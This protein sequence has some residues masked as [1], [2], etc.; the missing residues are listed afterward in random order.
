MSRAI[1]V[2]TSMLATLVVLVGVCSE[3]RAGSL[4]ECRT[5]DRCPRQLF[6]DVHEF[7]PGGVT[8]ADVAEAHARD[9]VVQERH[10]VEFEKYWVDERE[11]RVYCLSSAPDAESVVSTHRE[12]HGLVPVS[13]HPVTEGQAAAL[14][15]TGRLFLDIHRLGAGNVT[16][17]AVAAAHE[18]DLAVQDDYGVNFVQYWVDE[19]EGVVLCLSEASTSGAVRDTHREAHG[20]MPDRILEVIQGE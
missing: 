10:D 6:V 18:Q 14:R 4:R 12:A 19:T 15:G 9:L 13:V 17:E 7:T 8:A 20:L 5:G 3:P 2:W 1:S 11:G 16:A